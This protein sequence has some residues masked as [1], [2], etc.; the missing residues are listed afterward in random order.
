MLLYNVTVNIEK[1]TEEEWVIW[2]KEVHIPDVLAT[3][4]FIENKFYKIL[5]D[6]EDGS[7]NYSVQYFT[8]HMDKILDYQKRFAPKLQ[9]DTK[10]RF[11]EKFV[12]FR[13]LL[14]TVE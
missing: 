7:V 3:G 4:M 6:S 11:G 14:E 1:D 9:Q 12:V 13:T 10:D 2:M 5:H 8:D